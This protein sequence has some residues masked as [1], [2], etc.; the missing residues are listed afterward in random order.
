MANSF[1]GY[2]FFFF[3][4][5]SGRRIEI[6]GVENQEN[7]HLLGLFSPFTASK[8]YLTELMK[9]TQTQH[10][11]RSRH[12]LVEIKDTQSSRPPCCYHLPGLPSS[13]SQ[14]QFFQQVFHAVT[15]ENGCTSWKE[16]CKSTVLFCSL[17]IKDGSIQ[18]RFFLFLFFL[19]I[20]CFDTVQAHNACV[21]MKRNKWTLEKPLWK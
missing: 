18:W 9:C 10:D 15:H 1:L 2:L 5:L 7:K 12:D 8:L 6:L 19:F 13:V 14:E 11:T 4:L 3:F 21:P 17:L 16:E 20:S